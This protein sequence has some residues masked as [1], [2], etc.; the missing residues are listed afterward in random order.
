MYVDE[1]WQAAVAYWNA[2]Q[3]TGLSFI[4]TVSKFFNGPQGIECG[5]VADKNNCNSGT[6]CQ[7]GYYAAGWMIIE[8]LQLVSDVSDDISGLLPVLLN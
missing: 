6:A 3:N 2:N 5:V 1:A 7:N 4:E 8:S